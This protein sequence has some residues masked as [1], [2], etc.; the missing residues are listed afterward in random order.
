MSALVLSTHTQ[1]APFHIQRMSSA[2]PQAALVVR[3]TFG[4]GFC[5]KAFLEEFHLWLQT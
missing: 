3:H 4:C 1:Q 2:A 5:R